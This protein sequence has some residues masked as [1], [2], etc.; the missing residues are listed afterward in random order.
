MDVAV[1][2]NGGR[3]GVDDLAYVNDLRYWATC[4]IL[5]K[6]VKRH[7]KIPVA[8]LETGCYE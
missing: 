1:L 4:A 2:A 8:R 6:A 3:N 5:A 7:A